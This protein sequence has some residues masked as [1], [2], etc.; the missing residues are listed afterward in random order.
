[1]PKFCLGLD[2]DY[3]PHLVIGY[4]PADHQVCDFL[5]INLP[6]ADVYC[7]HCFFIEALFEQMAEVLAD[8]LA[9][10]DSNE[11]AF[12]FRTKMTEGQSYEGHNPFRANFYHDVVQRALQKYDMTQVL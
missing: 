10:I 2:V 8:D 4:P 5:A 1:M 7:R 9:D 6:R 12:H 3:L 11:L